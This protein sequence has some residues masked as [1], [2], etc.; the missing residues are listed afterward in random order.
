MPQ[1]NE[2]LVCQT[3]KS[4]GVFDRRDTRPSTLIHTCVEMLPMNWKHGKRPSA[5]FPVQ[6]QP[7][8]TRNL[9]YR[10]KHKTRALLLHDGT[11]IPNPSLS[12]EI[13]MTALLSE[14]CG[15]SRHEIQHVAL[16]R[17]KC[18]AIR[19]P[20]PAKLPPPGQ[21][22]RVHDKTRTPQTNLKKG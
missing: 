4:H 15:P 16:T 20:R 6:R 12:K 13:T 21:Q 8:P 19:I 18:F 10:V 11:L 5:A 7:V 14:K 17:V 1:K 2:G 9:S 3:S 22:K